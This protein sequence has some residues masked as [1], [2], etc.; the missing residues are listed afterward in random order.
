MNTTAMSDNDKTWQY[1]RLGHERPEHG[2]CR[3]NPA[4]DP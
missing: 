3:Q 1:R 2:R 4:E